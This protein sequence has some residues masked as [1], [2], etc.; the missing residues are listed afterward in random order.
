MKTNIAFA[1]A[2]LAAL[3]A[4]PGLSAD[5]TQDEIRALVA[6]GPWPVP[7]RA[8]PSNRVSGKREAIELG[9]RL[10]FDKRLSGKGNFSCGSCHVPERNWTD[11]QTRGAAI[12][13]VT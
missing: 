10:F 4:V 8:D 7:I 1:L 12:A 11:N 6:H 9:E 3:T 13:E 2:A 5:F